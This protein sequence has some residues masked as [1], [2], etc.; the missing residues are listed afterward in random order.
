MVEVSFE[1]IV[2]F[3]GLKYIYLKLQQKAKLSWDKNMDQELVDRIKGV[4]N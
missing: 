1:V 3:L 2:K 4:I